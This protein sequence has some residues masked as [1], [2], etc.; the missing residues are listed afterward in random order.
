MST[1]APQS[2]PGLAETQQPVSGEPQ[3]S[4]GKRIVSWNNSTDHKVIGYLYLITLFMFVCISGVMPL[5][6]RAVV[7]EPGIQIVQ[8]HSHFNELMTMRATIMLLVFATTLFAGF[9]RASMTIQLGAPDAA[10]PLLD[11][12][13]YM[14]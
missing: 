2:A 10:F 7:F 3:H 1:I 13:T 6:I 5:S 4:L 9:A 11:M 14:L 12:F 8:I